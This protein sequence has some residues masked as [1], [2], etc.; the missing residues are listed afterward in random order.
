VLAVDLRRPDWQREE[1]RRQRQRLEEINR[2]LENIPP[3]A[4]AIFNRTG[5]LY[6]GDTKMAALVT[7][8][9]ITRDG[10]YYLVAAPLSG[11]TA[12]SFPKWI[13][14]AISGTQPTV[15]LYNE[16]DEMI[17]RGYEFERQC[18]AERP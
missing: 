2:L 13:E 16:E 7:R 11:E 10:D 4:R 8:A 9:T 14:D 5:M 18:A 15:R 17:G 1:T 3:R 6:S 12:L